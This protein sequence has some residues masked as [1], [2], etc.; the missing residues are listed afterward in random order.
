MKCRAGVAPGRF[1]Q[2][3]ERADNR[4]KREKAR[5]TRERGLTIAQLWD[6]ARPQ[7]IL[8]ALTTHEVAF[9]LADTYAAIRDRVRDKVNHAETLAAVMAQAVLSRHLGAGEEA[10]TTQSV[11]DAHCELDEAYRGLANSRGF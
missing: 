5:E 7:Q 2:G 1:E 9:T 11:I 4:T 6:L 3:W 10:Y 8:A